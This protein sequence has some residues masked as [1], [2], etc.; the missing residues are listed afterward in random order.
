M[1][2]TMKTNI[3]GLLGLNEEH[4]TLDTPVFEKNLSS[5]TWGYADM[6]RTIT[7]NKKLNSKQKADAVEHENEHV[8]QMRRGEA[9]F[10]SNNVYHQPD[11]S[12]PIN[13]YARIGDGMLVKNTIIPVG[14]AASPVEKDV[15]NKTKK[16][17][18][19]LS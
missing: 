5:K 8:M 6:D 11:K 2:Y 17:P 1:G 14:H 10:D 4:S 18:V 16:H 13:K 19:K 7:I 12:K 3:P 9:W 15:Y